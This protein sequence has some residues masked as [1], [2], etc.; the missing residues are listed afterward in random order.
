[1]LSNF[2]SLQIVGGAIKML[3]R[4]VAFA[5]GEKLNPQTMVVHVEKATPGIDG[6]YQLINNEFC[7]HEAREVAF[8]NR[9]Q[10]LG[11]PG[12]RKAKLSYHP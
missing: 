11:V 9:E 4:V 5:L 8:V 7:A 10:D 2:T 6:L 12:L 3:G 1:M